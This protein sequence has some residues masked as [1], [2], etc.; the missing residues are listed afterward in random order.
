[1]FGVLDTQYI[2]LPA[3]IDQTYLEGLRTASGLSFPAVLRSIDQRLAAYNSY[4]DPLAAALMYPTSEIVAER[5]Q[6]IAFVVE[7]SSEYTVPRPQYVEGA[8]SALP[9]RKWDVSTQW[10]EDGLEEMT[11]NRINLQIDSIVLG[12]QT[13]GRKEVLRRLFDDSEVRVDPKT[14]MVNPGFAGSGTGLNA[15]TIPFPS[16]APLPG[17]YTLYHRDTA[18]NL[19]TVIK[20]A[21]N[22]LKKWQTGPFDLIAPQ[23]QIDAIAAL[24]DFVPVGSALIRGNPDD[25]EALVDPNLYVGVYDKDIRVR[26]AIEDFTDPNIAIFKTFGDL[27]PQNALAWRYDAHAGRGRDA[28]L[29]SRSMYPLDQAIV[30]QRFGVGTANRT[31]AAL[32]R[33]DSSGGYVAPSIV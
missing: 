19:A 26:V 3:N 15:F 24:A 22:K 10:T 14:P 5:M 27:N 1:M 6:A 2:D 9:L 13:H 12:F 11:L 33:I 7:E 17:G 23:T 21:R 16:G 31:A 28:F 30:V 8:A 29:R 4:V 32:I 18:A 25:P 20:T